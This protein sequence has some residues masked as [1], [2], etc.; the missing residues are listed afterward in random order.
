MT[1]L[2]NNYAYDAQG[3]LIKDEQEQIAQIDW[4]VVGKVKRV[5][6][7]ATSEK[8]D[9]EFIYDA[10]G[11]RITK[12]VKPKNGATWEYTYYIRNAS[13]NP[14]G[15]YKRSMTAT[16][17]QQEYLD[18]LE[19]IEHSIYGS[20]RLGLDVETKVLSERIFEAEEQIDGSLLET[21]TRSLA[22]E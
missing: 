21:N 15:V 20:A 9:L 19:L 12:I 13:G 11:N 7:T 22:C 14:M 6:R 17:N 4:T 10:M 2:A 3:N 5:T 16:E 8:P 1:S 18:K